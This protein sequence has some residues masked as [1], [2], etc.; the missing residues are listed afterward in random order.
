MVAS[1]VKGVEGARDVGNGM[2]A[3]KASQLR[4]FICERSVSSTNQELL[5]YIAL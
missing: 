2:I 1:V 3:I 5:K 4:F